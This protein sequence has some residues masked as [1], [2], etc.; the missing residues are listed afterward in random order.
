MCMKPSD[1]HI[2]EEVE[3]ISS[4]IKTGLFT[5]AVIFIAGMAIIYSQKKMMQTTTTLAGNVISEKELPIYCVDT[6]EP[7]I[8]LS[9]DAAWGERRLL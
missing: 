1:L 4:F 3:K 7:K 9:F 2:N 5:L 8:A 6:Q